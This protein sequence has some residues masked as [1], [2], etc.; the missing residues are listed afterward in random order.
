MKN[1]SVVILCFLISSCASNPP[2][3]SSANEAKGPNVGGSVTVS[4]PP[5]DKTLQNI[6]NMVLLLGIIKY[7]SDKNKE[8]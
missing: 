6:M 3:A 2:S 7:A 5:K 4:P 8:K 1:L